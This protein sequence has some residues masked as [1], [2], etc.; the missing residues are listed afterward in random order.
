MATGF[1]SYADGGVHELDLEGETDGRVIRPRP[2]QWVLYATL[3][4]EHVS[5]G[6]VL[7]ILA[8]YAQSMKA[9]D[10]ETG[11]L[12]GV[13]PLMN[14]AFAPILGRLS[15]RFGRRPVLLTTILGSCTSH[16][17]CGLAP[18]FTWLLVARMIG[19]IADANTGAAQAYIADVTRND[20][21][22]AGMGLIGVATGIGYVIG[23][24]MASA[25][26]G[27]G[28]RVPFFAAAVLS[29]SSFTTALLL[30][31]EPVRSEAKASKAASRA[32][33][34]ATLRQPHV[35]CLIVVA[36]L[37]ASSVSGI[38]GTLPLV[39]D[40]QLQLDQRHVAYVFAYWGA[41]MVIA[42][43]VLL[44][45]LAPRIREASLV[46]SGRLASALAMIAFVWVD[47]MVTLLVVLFVV[48]IGN[49]I[50]SPS[51]WSLISRSSAADTRGAVLGT[52]HSFAALGR[53][54]GPLIATSA[55]ALGAT[56]PIV[57][58][59]AT[60]IIASLTAIL[61]VV[62]ERRSLTRSA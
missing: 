10:L 36:L 41:L 11:L 44:R 40:R 58:S 30:L 13:Y 27:V 37:T 48:A 45:V 4:L 60:M 46:I 50:S 20:S 52:A 56:A 42:Q 8:L 3:Q 5:A 43:G 25:L 35:F 53:S 57:A 32:G 7:P 61:S 22:A 16:L 51:L 54:V 2:S 15:D 62:L 14:L 9:S 34:V 26:S 18:S 17:A 23:P 1:S 29:A 33:L 59:G 19:G 21:R 49:G 6:I 39:L 24:A 12:L 31:G 28:A 47:N 55:L 38:V